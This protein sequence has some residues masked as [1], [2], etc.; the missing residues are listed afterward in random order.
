MSRSLQG[1]CFLALNEDE[2]MTSRLFGAVI[3]SP[4]AI[5]HCA[6]GKPS[7]VVTQ[8]FPRRARAGRRRRRRRRRKR[9]KKKQKKTKKKKK[10]MM[11]MKKKTMMKK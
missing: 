1:S 9:E 3:P 6:C 11:V 5:G 8:E 2:E 7:Q 10:K 4:V